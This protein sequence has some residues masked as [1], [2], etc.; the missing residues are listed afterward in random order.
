M[1]I[2]ATSVV[3]DEPLPSAYDLCLLSGNRQETLPSNLES[4]Y[5]YKVTETSTP[6]SFV[7]KARDLTFSDVRKVLEECL[8][9]NPPDASSSQH[10]IQFFGVKR[11]Q[12]KKVPYYSLQKREKDLFNL[13][14]HL[15]ECVRKT[16]SHIS[17]IDSA[18][19]SAFQCY[20]ILNQC[21]VRLGDP[22]LSE[23]AISLRAY[24]VL[25]RLPSCPLDLMD[26]PSNL[27]DQYFFVQD[28]LSHVA[29]HSWET[30]KVSNYL[31][32]IIIQMAL[33][34]V[35]SVRPYPDGCPNELAEIL[36]TASRLAA[37]ETLESGKKEWFIV[38]AAIWSSWQRA[39][40]LCFYFDLS[41]NLNEG[42]NITYDS[43]PH[44]RE[45]TP[46]PN[47]SVRKMSELYASKGKAE[48]M[49]SWAFEL[50]RKDPV[51]L[52]MDF[53]AFHD[54]YQQ[55]WG[56]SVPRCRPESGTSCLG[57]DP[58]DCRRFKGLIIYNQSV[59]DSSCSPVR[60][61][62]LVWDEASYRAEE[63]ARAVC[64]DEGLEE[65]CFMLR[66]CKASQKTLAICTFSTLF[67]F[68]VAPYVEYDK[69]CV[70]KWHKICLNTIQTRRANC[71]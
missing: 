41:D 67:P 13:C 42:F 61:R 71:R 51:C 20:I 36:E 14:Q 23:D 30:L 19:S 66:Y 57:K 58:E 48:S 44:L 9:K 68:D 16:D 11:W 4:R 8:W 56:M 10:K 60:C 34:A 37:E 47:L 22:E 15:R 21:R 32:V 40:M 5:D 35:G 49:C 45:T 52:G 12:G 33:S 54:R 46:V 65:T 25:R 59:H 7:P 1:H 53:R 39:V 55:L 31:S 24:D 62:K 26:L 50:L 3:L 64:L 2:R 28:P 70:F 69:A 29:G 43:Q 38:R 27:D 63:G 18:V 6:M 17:E